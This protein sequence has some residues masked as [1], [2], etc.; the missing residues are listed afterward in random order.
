[1]QWF[2]TESVNLGLGRVVYISWDESHY[3]TGTTQAEAESK[4]AAHSIPADFVATYQRAM[5]D[6]EDGWLVTNPEHPGVIGMGGT[7][8]QAVEDFEV[9]KRSRWYPQRFNSMV[10]LVRLAIGNSAEPDRVNIDAEFGRLIQDIRA[11]TFKY[12]G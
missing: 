9:A 6:A 1:M 4:L 11:G 2:K 3:E 7:P 8:E 10:G 5:I 12:E